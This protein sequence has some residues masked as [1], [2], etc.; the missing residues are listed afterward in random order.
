MFFPNNCFRTKSDAK[1]EVNELSWPESSA[2]SLWAWLSQTPDKRVDD[3]LRLKNQ[4]KAD[5]MCAVRLH[6]LLHQKPMWFSLL[7]VVHQFGI[8]QL[9]Y[10][11]SRFE[12]RPQEQ[13]VATQFPSDSRK[14]V[15]LET[16]DSIDIWRPLVWISCFL[17][18]SSNFFRCRVISG[19][20]LLHFRNS[21]F[22][23]VKFVRWVSFR[24]YCVINLKFRQTGKYA[25]CV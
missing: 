12:I 20:V 11:K 18:C 23:L 24:L 19:W 16:S 3:C 9:G 2:T 17:L 7:C 6:L 10:L 5:F 25:L 13:L 21:S 4:H 22:T 14:I 1:G 15:S 8:P